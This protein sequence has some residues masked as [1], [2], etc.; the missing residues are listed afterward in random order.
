MAEIEVCPEPEFKR[1]VRER[2]ESFQKGLNSKISWT[3]TGVI[4]AVISIIAFLTYA[5]YSGEQER[6]RKDIK[7]NCGKVQ[8]LETRT[9]VMETEFVHIRDELEELNVQ[10]KK[11]FE[12]I[13]ERLQEIKRE[14]R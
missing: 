6:Q 3:M 12:V 1:F 7:E 8:K 9:T 14:R 13:L 11:Q 4:V 2:F 10:Q 5:A